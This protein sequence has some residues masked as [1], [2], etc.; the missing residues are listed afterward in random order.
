MRIVIGLAA[1]CSTMLALAQGSQDGVV[2]TSNRASGVFELY[3][4]TDAGARALLPGRNASALALS[5]DGRRLAFVSSSGGNPDLY[6]LDMEGGALQRLTDSPGADGGPAWS[7]DGRQ[8]VFQ[9]Y[10]DGTS[11]L[12]LMAADGSQ[13]RRLT[14]DA[15]EESS[16]AFAPDGK[17]VAYIVK[18]G[19]HDAQLRYAPLDGGPPRILGRDPAKGNEAMP[20]WSP[21][22]KRL[23]YMVQEG[24]NVHV[25]LMNADGS[26]KQ[27]LT[28]GD[29]ANNDPQWSPDGKRLL[30]LGARGATRRQQLYTVNADG[31]A[32]TLL[33][34]GDHEHL[35][36]RWSADGSHI[37]FVR[38][39]GR[40]G[41]LYSIASDGK[42]LRKLSDGAEYDFE[43][44]VM[45]KQ[46]WRKTAAR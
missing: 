1:A 39:E 17:G 16:A 27:A 33:T 32:E 9:S 20:S 24:R 37:Y 2:F 11:K 41:Q 7:P 40:G 22:G 23:T 10:R 21:D 6:V 34:S 14:A 31:S 28:R 26:G 36:A 15:A 43:I 30:F 35:L 19:R 44:A 8:L 5:P 25:H 12:Y 13:V 46:A 18:L 38:F 4:L 42:H 29:A 45:P 3:R